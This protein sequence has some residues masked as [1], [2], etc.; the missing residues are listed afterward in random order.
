MEVEEPLAD[1]I[2][3][4]L[5]AQL[6]GIEHRDPFGIAALDQVLDRI[7]VAQVRFLQTQQ[8]EVASVL[9]RQLQATAADLPACSLKARQQT[10][11]IIAGVNDEQTTQRGGIV[12]D[13]SLAP[14]YG[15][16][17]KQ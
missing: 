6:L 11:T 9:Q 17:V 5:H 13:R 8:A 7:R 15:F 1:K 4:V 14:I 2:T 12:H 10:V 3:D 16:Y